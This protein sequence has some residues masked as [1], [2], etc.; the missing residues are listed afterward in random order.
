MTPVRLRWAAGSFGLTLTLGATA[1]AVYLLSAG[2]GHDFPLDHRQIHGHTQ[3]FG[4][5]GL[6]AIGA[7]EAAL[8]AALQAPPRRLP[9][10]TFWLFL[11]AILLR[12]V[13]QPLAALPAARLGVVLSAALLLAGTLVVV[14]YVAFLLGEAR[15]SHRG[16]ARRLALASGATSVYLVFSVGLNAFQALWI[17]AGRGTV[18]PRPLTEAFSDAALPGA[19]L[20][21]GFTLGLRLAPSLGRTEVNRRLVARA[22]AVQA[23]GVGLS[24]VAWIPDLLPALSLALRDLGQ[25]LL[26]VAVVLYLRATGLASG[27]GTRPVADPSLRASDAAVRL[28]FFAL[29]LWA[30]VLCA[31]V[32]LARLTPLAVRNRWWEDGTRHLF[33]V[34]F[35]T[36]LVVGAAGRLSP[37]F[38][39][40]PLASGALQAASA[41]LVGGGAAL[42]LLQFPALAW[43][44]LTLVASTAGAPVV[45]GLVLLAW[46]LRKT[47]RSAAARPPGTP[48]PPIVGAGSAAGGRG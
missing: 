18:L 34:G 32:A 36:L 6:L 20:A 13:C 26:A 3:V 19:L 22:L 33:T 48:F 40:R 31:T 4:F 5:A 12:N 14:S 1:G 11:S 10:A 9:R 38:F 21:A 47:A 41:L 45:S 35:V 2:L 17:A 46:N 24:L 8:P 28:S 29:G 43:P 30:A 27:R 7:V 25:L 23:G 15:P 37:A 16:G 39:G 44:G 42:R